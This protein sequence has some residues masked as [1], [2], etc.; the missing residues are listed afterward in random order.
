ML[1]LEMCILCLLFYDQTVQNQVMSD[2]SMSEFDTRLKIHNHYH[3]VE[4]NLKLY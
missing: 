1:F 2:K 4:A 3:Q